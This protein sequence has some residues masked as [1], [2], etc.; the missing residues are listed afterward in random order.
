MDTIFYDGQCGFCHR[1][2]RFLL[3]RDRGGERFRF[4]ALDSQAFRAAF[5]EQERQEFPDSLIVLTDDGAVLTRSTA[6]AHLL[7]RLGGGW[8]VLGTL[9]SLT[10][11]RA[12]DALYDSI[13]RMRHHLFASPAEACPLLPPE[14]RSRFLD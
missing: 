11:L 14:L 3:A 7:R 12:R 13:A 9:L 1:A 2:V 5:S 4:A 10:P 6:T 8:R